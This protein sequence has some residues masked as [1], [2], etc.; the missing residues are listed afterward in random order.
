MAIEI[1]PLAKS[2]IAGAVD[3]VQKAFVDDPYFLWA[4]NDPSQVCLPQSIII[5][6]VLTHTLLA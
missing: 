2:D 3:C 4:F 6:I 5:S 1:V